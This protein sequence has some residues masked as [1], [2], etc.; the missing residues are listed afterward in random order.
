MEEGDNSGFRYSEAHPTQLI[1]RSLTIINTLIY[2][3]LFF[4]PSLTT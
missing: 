4:Q 2:Q 1:L 3:Y